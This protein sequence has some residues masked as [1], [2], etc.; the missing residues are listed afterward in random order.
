MNNVNPQDRR[1]RFSE[2]PPPVIPDHQVIRCIGRGGYG[3]V[4]LARNVIGQY[5][6]VKIIYRDQLSED[7]PFER[8]FEAIKQYEPISRSHPGLVHVLQVGRNDAARHFYYVMELGDD[9][10]PAFAEKDY[11][12][13]TL[14]RVIARGRLPCAEAVE[15]GIALSEA[16]GHLHAH[17]LVHRDVK[18]SNIIFVG[19]KPKLADIGSVALIKEETSMLGTAGFI[20][21]EGRVSAQSDIFSLGKVLWELSTGSDRTDFP[22]VPE[23]ILASGDAAPFAELNAVILKACASSQAERYKTAADL[24]ADLEVLRV[25]KSVLRLRLLEKRISV[26]TQAAVAA[27]VLFLAAA[28]VLYFVNDARQREKKLRAA[29]YSASGARLVEE[30]NLHAAIPLLGEAMELEAHAAGL[31]K[32]ER[33]RVG[34]LLQQSPRL[35][36]IWTNE[37]LMT[38]V[39]FVSRRNGVLAAQGR[40]VQFLDIKTRAP[41]AADMHFSNRVDCLAVSMDGRRMIAGTSKGATLVDVE[42]MR[43]LHRWPV[44]GLITAAAFSADATRAAVA[45][46]SDGEPA[47]FIFDSVAPTNLPLLVLRGHRDDIESVDF[48]PTGKW[49]I[50][51]SRDGTARIWGA[52]TAKP[53]GAELNHSSWV[54]SARLSPDGRYIATAGHDRAVCI[55]DAA[56]QSLITRWPAHKDAV[57]RVA[58]SPDSRFILSAG[59]DHTARLWTRNGNVATALLNHDNPVT[60]VAFD[61]SGRWVVTADFGGTVKVWDVAQLRPQELGD[62]VF[63]RDGSRC[64]IA[65]NGGIAIYDMPGFRLAGARQLGRQF[66][67]HSFTDDG[68]SVAVSSTS[69]GETSI[70]VL[71]ENTPTAVWVPVGEGNI[72]LTASRNGDYVFTMETVGRERWRWSVWNS[73]TGD[74]VLGP[75]LSKAALPPS[76]AFAPTNVFAVSAGRDVHLWNLSTQR[77]LGTSLRAPRLVSALHFSTDGK[78]L[79]VADADNDWSACA[80]RIWDLANGRLVAGPFAHRDGVL[81]ATLSRDEKFVLTCSEDKTAIAWR[82]LN[83]EVVGPA[84]MHRQQ[85]IAARF[86]ADARWIVTAS[87]DGVVKVSEAATGFALAAP[88]Q[89]HGSILDCGFVAGDAGVWVR[90]RGGTSFWRFTLATNSLDEIKTLAGALGTA[91]VMRGR[92]GWS[93]ADTQRWRSAPAKVLS[94]LEDSGVAAWHMAEATASERAEDWFAAQF[95][96]RQLAHLEPTNSQFSARLRQA[97]GHWRAPATNNPVTTTP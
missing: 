75:T 40:R 87:R 57:T 74:R 89:H 44:R 70:A 92:G 48:E 86:N 61:A 14:S 50:T 69:N 19:G 2:G 30:D 63:T 34:M 20:A 51:A 11:T 53:V 62:A 15:I 4:W 73:R 12:P 23:E 65:T 7:R 43:E 71:G 93:E 55:W 24:R 91:S 35:L 47:V 83:S 72:E 96:W 95:H 81:N 36:A 41:I 79:L 80:A 88:F 78:Q 82:V 6:A 68:R 77:K 56:M 31:A 27:A 8:E 10:E 52:A 85:V 46:K 22:H 67:L 49:I 59:V 37:S 26:L 90:E 54:Y 64:A 33:L 17:G 60:D 84:I 42:R 9:D 5:R 76:R 66:Q 21:P 32:T 3:D 16:L 13:R 25:G 29:A 58:W 39:A 18:P 45:G 28:I 97:D 1:S 38:R 94:A